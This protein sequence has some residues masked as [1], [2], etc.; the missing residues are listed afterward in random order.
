MFDSEPKSS[1]GFLP[2]SLHSNSHWHLLGL[3]PHHQLLDNCRKFFTGLSAFPS[4]QSW[5]I[6]HTTDIFH[7]LTFPNSKTFN[8]F[9]V[10]S[11]KSKFLCPF[12]KVLHNLA[13]ICIPCLNPSNINSPFLQNSQRPDFLTFVITFPST[14][15]ELSP[16]FPN[17]TYPLRP[18]SNSELQVIRDLACIWT[19]LTLYMHTNIYTYITHTHMPAVIHCFVLLVI[20]SRVY[21]HRISSARQ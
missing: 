15:N 20:I 4:S 1:K 9:S 16:F 11:L 7:S 14:W 6:L 13:L 12:F 17:L 18:R 2:L 19:L 21:I 5:S 3:D 10:P 8:G